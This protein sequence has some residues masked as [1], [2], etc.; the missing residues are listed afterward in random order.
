MQ[1]PE[2]SCC[3]CNDWEMMASILELSVLLLKEGG[4]LPHLQLGNTHMISALDGDKEVK[5]KAD[6][7]FDS[8]HGGRI[9]KYT[10]VRFIASRQFYVI[11]N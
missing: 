2:L 4:Q 6:A 7:E 3:Q 9:H 1:I 8:I 5:K 11:T 10:Q